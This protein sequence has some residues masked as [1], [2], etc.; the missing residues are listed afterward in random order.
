LLRNLHHF[1]FDEAGFLGDGIPPD[2]KLVADMDVVVIYVL[3]FL[4]DLVCRLF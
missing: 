2:G 1:T 4:G 3:G